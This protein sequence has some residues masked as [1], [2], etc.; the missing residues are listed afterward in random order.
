VGIVKGGAFAELVAVPEDRVV[1]RPD[2][3][4]AVIAAALPLSGATA[5][6]AVRDK[7]QVAAG[8]RVL[9]TGA[10]GGVGSAAVQLAAAV[11]AHVTG[12]CR[13]VHLDL[14]AGL[15]AE[16]VIDR[17]RQAVPGPGPFD[18]IIHVA[19]RIPLGDLRRALA[20]GGRLVLVTGDG[21]RWMGPI[22]TL[23]AA[24]LLGL[25]TRQPLRPLVAP[26][27]AQDVQTLLQAHLAGQLTP[28]IARTY[29]LA[30]AATAVDDLW[31]GQ[32]AGKVVVIP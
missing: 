28:P 25:V 32:V 27:R 19:G 10:S 7:G 4:E 11:G 29:A 1:A 8:E 24:S 9:V 26:E 14:V 20:P 13:S 5:L 22:P 12:V 15:G 3:V 21:G 30:E 23:A 16:V 17:T 18:V 31:R 2:G 6:H